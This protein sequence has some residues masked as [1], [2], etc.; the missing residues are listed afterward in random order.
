MNIHKI[1]GFEL[2]EEISNVISAPNKAASKVDCHKPPSIVD[3]MLSSHSGCSNKRLT[4]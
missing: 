2:L 1:T 3:P 4:I